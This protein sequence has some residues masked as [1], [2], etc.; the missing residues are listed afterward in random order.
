MLQ[1][2]AEAGMPDEDQ[3][4]NRREPRLGKGGKSLR[5]IRPSVWLAGGWV[6]LVTVSAVLARILPL[7]D[8][9]QVGLASPGQGPGWSHLLGTD[10]IGR[11]IMSRLVYGGRV[12]LVVAVFAVL[13]GMVAGGV[14]GIA[15]G[16][17]RG[18][19][20]E[21]VSGAVNVMLAFPAIV[22]AL[23]AVAFLGPSLTSVVSVIAVL[24]VAPY[25]RFVRA[26]TVATVQRE[27]VMAARMLGY[28]NKRILFREVIPNVLP[29]LLSFAFIGMGVAI[30][31]EGGLSYL[32]LSVRPPTASWGN[33]IAEGSSNISTIPLLSVWPSLA[34]LLTV[35]ALNVLGEQMR[36]RFDVREGV[37]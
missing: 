4:G 35:L 26:N 12:S 9:N 33:M 10:E 36:K 31:V 16:Y 6:A 18:W 11:D 34:L 20:D 19:A 29:S 8:P 28:S 14:L 3:P 27:Y 1:Q 5:R 17:W 7:P 37:L 25:A 21:L 13:V 30:A 24:S 15:A 22:F 32:A 23:A 2:A